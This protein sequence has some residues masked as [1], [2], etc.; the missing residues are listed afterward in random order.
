MN[1]IRRG[2]RSYATPIGPLKTR[3]IKRFADNR[4]PTLATV[5]PTVL[6]CVGRTAYSEASPIKDR[7][8]PAATGIKMRQGGEFFIEGDLGKG[9]CEFL[10]P[11]VYHINDL[12]NN[13]YLRLNMLSEWYTEIPLRGKPP[14]TSDK[15]ASYAL[16]SN[17]NGRS[18]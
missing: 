14:L 11:A 15:G 5:T 17:R 13:E 12:V 9:S 18:Y 10:Q 3:R 1:K 8:V 7:Q 6:V 4:I 2:K 16:S